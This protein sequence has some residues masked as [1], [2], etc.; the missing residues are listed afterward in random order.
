MSLA[1]LVTVD[2]HTLDGLLLHVAPQ[3]SDEYVR[4]IVGDVLVQRCNGPRLQQHIGV[5]LDV[6][7]RLAAV[8]HGLE[9]PVHGG[10]VRDLL[11]AHLDGLLLQPA[12]SLGGGCLAAVDEEGRH[13]IHEVGASHAQHRFGVL[14]GHALGGEM[15]G[16]VG[17]R[18]V[19][20]LCCQLPVVGQVHDGVLQ[21]FGRHREA[22]TA[23]GQEHWD[24]PY[25]LRHHRH[26]AVHCLHCHQGQALSVARDEQAIEVAHGPLWRHHPAEI[27]RI[28][29]AQLTGPLVHRAAERTLAVH[30]Q[31]E[32]VG[33]LGQ[34]LHG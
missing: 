17:S 24:I 18:A 1:Y 4:A 30:H 15:L 34:H 13:L 31:P 9:G 3:V 2:F 6:V 22:S 29:H 28:L 7:G 10:H 16:G 33:Q 21:V 8:D 11:D 25:R 5:H 27:H 20:F 23:I 14:L 12:P 32:V 19:S 26:A